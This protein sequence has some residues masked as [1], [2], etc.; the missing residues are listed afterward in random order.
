VKCSGT[1]GLRPYL[2]TRPNADRLPSAQRYNIRVPDTPEDDGKP[3][4]RAVYASETTGLLAIAVLLLV[5]TL[6]RYW[7]HIHWSVR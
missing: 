1:S 7:H 6:I 5:L 2:I 3:R 4:R